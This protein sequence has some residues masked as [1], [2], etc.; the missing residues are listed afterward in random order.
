[1]QRRA[2]IVDDEPSLGELFREAIGATGMQVLA[3]ET[4]ADAAAHLGKEKFD[5]VLLGLRMPALDGIDLTRQ[6]RGSGFNQ[7]TPVI[8]VSEDQQTA[9]VS[10]AFEAGANFFLYKPVDKKRLLQ[11]IRATQGSIE[12]ERRRFRRVP[13]RLKV[14][15]TSET[16]EVFGETVDVSLDGM[17][18]RAASIMPARSRVGVALHLLADPKPVV[19]T[20]TVTRV[21][22]ADQMG[23]HLSR[24]SA[25]E[26]ARLQDFLLPLIMAG[27]SD[28]AGE[29]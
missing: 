28:P 29:R 27:G 23:I 21:I 16:A 22:G 11:L 20:G 7:M 17:L 3:L 14:R 12:N 15:L 9:A 1:M 6:V 25:E 10:Q 18:V 26:N 2:L 19:G 5:V 8:V 13:C 4:C 24:M